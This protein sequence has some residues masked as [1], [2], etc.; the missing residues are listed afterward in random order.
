[1]KNILLVVSLLSA[2]TLFIAAPGIAATHALPLAALQGGQQAPAQT[3]T[4]TVMKAGDAFTLSDSENRVTYR[5]DD[6]Q[7]ASQF[8]GKK[9]KVT[10]TLDAQS[11]TIRIQSIEETS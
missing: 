5:L 6:A 8:E 1:M 7:K 2:S 11:R 9:V 10:G 4:G 3:F